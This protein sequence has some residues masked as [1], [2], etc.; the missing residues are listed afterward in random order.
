MVVR[1]GGVVVVRRVVVVV[2]V[3]VVVGGGA[4]SEVVVVVVE[5]LDVVVVVLDDADPSDRGAELLV[6]TVGPADCEAGGIGSTAPNSDGS[7]GRSSPSVPKANNVQAIA[8]T[9]APMASRPCPFRRVD[10]IWCPS[11]ESDDHWKLIVQSTSPDRVSHAQAT[12][13]PAST[14]SERQ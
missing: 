10:S 3:A 11:G 5:V 14:E 4:P 13:R 8:P 12:G 9:T 7:S 6:V 1:C 2:V